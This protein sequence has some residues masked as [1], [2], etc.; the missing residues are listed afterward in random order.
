[1]GTSS[2]LWVKHRKCVLSS[3][4]V[5][6]CGRM[7]CDGNVLASRMS[8]QQS[9]GRSGSVK[10]LPRCCFSRSQGAQIQSAP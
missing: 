1:M 5:M 6:L 2:Q 10:E 8:V 3:G 7:P 4:V 9:R